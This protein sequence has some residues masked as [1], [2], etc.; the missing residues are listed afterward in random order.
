[1]EAD[2]AEEVCVTRYLTS[3]VTSYSACNQM[4]PRDKVRFG[5]GMYTCGQHNRK[6][7]REYARVERL[8]DLGL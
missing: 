1:M 3:G 7:D 2:G 6:S 8:W 4:E 5:F